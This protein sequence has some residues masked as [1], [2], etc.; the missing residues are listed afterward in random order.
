M[1]PV[2]DQIRVKL[3][4]FE[5]PLDLLLHLIRTQHIDIAAIPIATITRQYLETIQ[6]MKELDLDIAGEYLVMAATLILI[7]SRML[8]PPSQQGDD[9]ESADVMR[10]ELVR[11][12]KEYEVFKQ[13]GQHLQT[14]ETTRHQFHMR[15]VN[16]DDTD[17]HTE[18]VIDASLVD[19]L[20][21]LRHILDR[22]QELPQHIV[23][24]K[25]VS[26][27]MKMTTILETLTRRGSMN[28]S[29][30]FVECESRQEIIGT[31][32]ALLELMRLQ[33]V[34]ARQRRMFGEI[35]LVAYRPAEDAGV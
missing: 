22:E 13:A 34:K 24:T 1:D 14:L 15:P 33:A 2:S 19:L 5:G 30:L 21:S 23:R 32:L 25:P 11:R 12:L 4:L 28:F 20:K 16:A 26:V 10:D 29:D 35:R 9:E 27:R 6:I 31:F 7:K 3:E 8:L 18:W 17:I